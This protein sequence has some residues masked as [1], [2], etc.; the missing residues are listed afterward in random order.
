MLVAAE[1]ANT[2]YPLGFCNDMILGSEGCAVF[3]FLEVF[4]FFSVTSEVFARKVKQQK[5]YK[6]A[7]C[8]PLGSKYAQ[9]TIWGLMYSK[10]SYNSNSC[11]L[12]KK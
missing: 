2:T 9:P 3:C 8:T 4:C 12:C 1:V 5:Y 11:F 7:L 6:T 10:N